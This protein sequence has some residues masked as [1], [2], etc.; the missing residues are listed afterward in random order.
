MAHVVGQPA[1]ARTGQGGE[2]ERQQIVGHVA[3]FAVHGVRLAL[4]VVQQAAGAPIDSGHGDAVHARELIERARAPLACQQGRA[5]NEHLV[6][7]IEALDDHAGAVL[8]GG[9]HAQG[10]VDALLH[11]VHGAV[12][13][14]H[15]QAHL[16]VARQKVR[17]QLAQ[18]GL[19]QR[20]RATHA[21]RA[22]WRL[23]HLRHQ[24][25][26]RLRRFA[27]RLAMA[28]IR[29]AHLGQRQAARGA[30]QQAQAQARLQLGHA[31]REARFW[32]AQRPPGSGK[33]AALGHL[34]E[35]QH[36]VEVLHGGGIVLQTGQSIAIPLSYQCF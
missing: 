18:H 11:Q 21:H 14:L 36:V 12:A 28:Q 5:G 8:Q 26:R 35:K 4:G 27:H 25:S 9:A 16:G 29:L 20:H 22:A 1:P 7:T 10:D 34:G 23:L 15:F 33:T 13:D 6:R 32:N 2:L 24:L 19:R 31:A 30:L 3:R 17:D